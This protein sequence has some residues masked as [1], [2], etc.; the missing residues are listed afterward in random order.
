MPVTNYINRQVNLEPDDYD[1]VWRLAQERGLGRKG[2]S[3]A[4]RMIIREWVAYRAAARQPW[5]GPMPSAGGP[6][7]QAA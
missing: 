2:F 5:A 3:A 1:A 6:E 7:G 4:L